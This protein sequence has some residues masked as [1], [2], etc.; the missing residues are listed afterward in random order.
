MDKIKNEH[1]VPS[2]GNTVLCKTWAITSS[3]SQSRKDTD[4]NRRKYLSMSEVKHN[5]VQWE[6]SEVCQAGMVKTDFS[7]DTVTELKLEGGL[8]MCPSSQTKEHVQRHAHEDRDGMFRKFQGF[9]LTD[10]REGF[11]IVRQWA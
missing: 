9:N 1:Y 2:M 3:C 8:G 7:K 5:K 10:A 4:A 6:Y 11:L